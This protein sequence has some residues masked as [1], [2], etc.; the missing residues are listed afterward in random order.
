M[1]SLAAK[2]AIFLRLI[3]FEHTLFAL[4]WALTGALV[5]ARGLPGRSVL[6]WVLVAMVGARTAA[7]SFN[8]LVD[9][10]FDAAN[11]RTSRRPSVTGELGGGFMASAVLISAVVFL[12]AAWR[13]NPLAFA[14]AGPTLVI[15][16]GYSLV[17]RFW[18]WSHFVLGL[19]LGLSP[20]GAWV[21]VRGSLDASWPALALGAAVVAWTTGFDILYA[22]QDEATDRRLGLHSVPARFGV[23]GALRWARL[24]HS[25]VVPALCLA[26]WTADMGRVYFMATA[27]VAGLLIWEHRLVRPDDLS[28]VNRAFFQVNVIIA[29]VVL[30]GVSLDLWMTA[31]G[32]S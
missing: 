18:A 3:R 15:L 2:P 6:L 7:M 11:P 29:F 24:S 16:L 30:L 9:R 23:R 13:L 5:A 14:W 28:Q 8:R 20:L 19:A 26:G 17:K 10:R 21:A 27:L 1:T 32:A 4:P 25:L 31:G 22:C 12:W